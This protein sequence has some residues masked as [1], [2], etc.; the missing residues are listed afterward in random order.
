MQRGGSSGGYPADPDR[1]YPA[2]RGGRYPG[3]DRGG[4][5][6]EGGGRHVSRG[7]LPG[8]DDV[9]PPPR[10]GAPRG[11]G[12]GGP[13]GYPDP[14]YRGGWTTTRTRVTHRQAATAA[15][16]A[17]ATISPRCRRMPGGPP[18]GGTGRR[19]RRDTGGYPDQGGYPGAGRYSDSGGYPDLGGYPGR[20]EYPAQDDD[21]DAEG[22]PAAWGG[23]ARD[24]PGESEW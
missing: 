8:D 20:R 15:T 23:E 11:T 18:A 16:R 2:G 7:R 12:H 1:G 22:V 24:E 9:L 4:Y 3:A 17:A 6:G 21:P 19:A 13:A 10:R 14:G 5:S